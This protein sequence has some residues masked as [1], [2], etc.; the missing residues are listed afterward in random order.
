MFLCLELKGDVPGLE[1]VY[2]A[3]KFGRDFYPLPITKRRPDFQS[4]P[5]IYSIEIHGSPRQLWRGR[6]SIME[7]IDI[8]YR[9]Q[10]KT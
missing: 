2:M 8:Y 6:T 3:V 10:V 5:S 4:L 7:R 9:R 1:C